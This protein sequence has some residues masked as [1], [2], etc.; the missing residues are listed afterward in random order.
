MTS[1][2]IRTNICRACDLRDYPEEL[3]LQGLT[4]CLERGDVED[5]GVSERGESLFRLS[6][7]RFNTLDSAFAEANETRGRFHTSLLDS[8]RGRVGELDATDADRII[9]AF[10]VFLGTVLG[11]AGE[12]CARNLVHE[13][14]VDPVEYQS[15]RRELEAALSMLPEGLHQSASEVFSETLHSPTA[16]QEAYLYTGGQVY[17]MT[18]ILN[19]DPELRALERIRFEDTTVL[20]DT[21]VLV[22]AVLDDLPDHSA[23]DR[24][25]GFSYQLGLRLR[26][27]ARTESEFTA[28]LD[29]ADAEYRAA[30]PYSPA[31]AA[32]FAPFLDNPFIEAW[33]SAYQAHGLSWGQFRVRISTWRAILASR[34]EI[35][36]FDAFPRIEDGQRYSGV[37]AFLTDRH[38]RANAADH[39]AQVLVGLEALIHAD[40]SPG[41]PFGSKYWFVTQDRTVASCAQAHLEPVSG[42]ICM[43][44]DEWVQYIAPFLGPDVADAN[45]ADVFSRLLGS[46]FFTSL[47]ANL[48]LRDLQPFT[49]PEVGELVADIPDEE[50]GRAVAAARRASIVMPDAATPSLELERFAEAVSD[51]LAK[52]R[53]ED[54]A[55]ARAEVSVESLSRQL[56]EEASISSERDL[57]LSEMRRELVRARRDQRTSLA[58]LGR[59]AVRAIRDELR[60]TARRPRRIFIIAGTLAVGIL[61]WAQGWLGDYWKVILVLAVIAQFLGLDRRVARTNVRRLRSR[62]DGD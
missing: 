28:L 26:Y 9:E 22:A 16:E 60:L 32:R 14:G 15:A 27:T 4:G 44:G 48:T 55:L 8:I 56:H 10:D 12:R 54:D 3:V 36:L 20:L 21:N 39:D 41:H 35:T 29:A 34:H 50:L 49:L 25:L 45:I 47:G 57:E 53:E 61:G 13:H 43:T 24:M 30:P 17:Y 37:K 23:V 38:R 18:A 42:S 31:T 51:E 5:A 11:S 52:R 2:G 62:R 59:K 40:Q 58:F 6:E 1:A 46:R 33:L 19:F 7:A